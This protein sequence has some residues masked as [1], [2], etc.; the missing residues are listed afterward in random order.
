MKWYELLFMVF[1]FAGALWP[2]WLVLWVA[3][4]NPDSKVTPHVTKIRIV[5]KQ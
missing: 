4:T 1:L 5:R 3:F 2:I